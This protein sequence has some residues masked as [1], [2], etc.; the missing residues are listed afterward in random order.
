MI[1]LV[2][3]IA[4]RR[5]D[6]RTEPRA[7]RQLAVVGKEAVHDWVV[8]AEAAEQQ[9]RGEAWRGDRLDL[10]CSL[11]GQWGKQMGASPQDRIVHT[12][13]SWMDGQ[14]TGGPQFRLPL[15]IF[16]RVGA[17]SFRAGDEAEAMWVAFVAASIAVPF[18]CPQEGRR[19]SAAS[20]AGATAGH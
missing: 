18:A 12:R 3:I 14:S 15:L 6:V 1:L 8:D 11:P 19:R 17:D 10:V 7:V 5:R 9:G 4:V 13:R 20:D 16:T 2:V